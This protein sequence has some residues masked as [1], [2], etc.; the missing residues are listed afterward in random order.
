MVP[1]PTHSGTST[2]APASP[3]HAGE[4]RHLRAPTD[5]LLRAAHLLLPAYSADAE[6]V[7]ADDVHAFSP[8]ADACVCVCPAAARGRLHGLQAAASRERFVAHLRTS[9]PAGYHVTAVHRVALGRGVRA[10]AL[11]EL[12]RGERT[13]RVI[14]EVMNET[15]AR[16]PLAFTS[17]GAIVSDYGREHLLR[18]ST[19]ATPSTD[20]L[21]TLDGHPAVPALT[22]WGTT[23]GAVWSI[24]SK[25]HGERARHMTRELASDILSFCASLSQTEQTPSAPFS[26]LAELR[27]ASP[28]RESIWSWVE[29][30]LS[31]SLPDVAIA[32]HGDLWLGNV[33]EAKGRLRGVV[34]WD[35]FDACAMPG[36]DLLHAFGSDGSDGFPRCVMKRP[37]MTDEFRTLTKGYWQG[38]GLS[39]TT[40]VLEAAGIAWWIGHVATA[41]NREPSLVADERWIDEHIDAVAP[42]FSSP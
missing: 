9:P 38:L 18:T 37:W 32:R 7:V 22:A 31:R 42:V 39:M 15:G 28:Q 26:D 14:D 6:V 3:A 34:D 27:F 17:G 2:G 25:L 1:P 5:A 16:P 11:I 29:E 23:A 4:M 13:P 10:G 12:H 21:R 33:L 30:R 20:A 24:E 36:A 8:A 35:G 19:D 40:D 41:V